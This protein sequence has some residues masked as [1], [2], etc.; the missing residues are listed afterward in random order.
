MACIDTGSD[1]R[2]R[3]RRRHPTTLVARDEDHPSIGSCC[4]SERRVVV[5][6]D[7]PIVVGNLIGA[8]VQIVA[9]WYVRHA[10]GER[11]VTTPAAP[12]TRAMASCFRLR[13]TARQSI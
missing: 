11:I 13:V 8:S 9:T 4:E 6:V 1:V 5:N 2:V 3:R 7:A 12:T 10:R